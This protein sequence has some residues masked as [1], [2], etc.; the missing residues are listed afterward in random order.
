MKRN[1]ERIYI[2]PPDNERCEFNITMSDNSKARCGK[3]KKLGVFCRQHISVIVRRF[4]LKF[5]Q[6]FIEN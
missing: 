5:G 4:N 1:G 6:V 2:D 3:R